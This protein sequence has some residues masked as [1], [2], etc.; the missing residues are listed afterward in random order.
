MT[1]TN[2]KKSRTVVAR[3][4]MAPVG[5]KTVEGGIYV[6]SLMGHKKYCL[7]EISDGQFEMVMTISDIN[8]ARGLATMLQV[9]LTRGIKPAVTPG[10]KE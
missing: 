8:E 6:G 5:V 9:A 3:E 1:G 4:H 10:T 2:E 7:Y